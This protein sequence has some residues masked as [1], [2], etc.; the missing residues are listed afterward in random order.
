MPKKFDMRLHRKKFNL[1]PLG[2]T[3]YFLLICAMGMF[4][5]LIWNSFLLKNR[6]MEQ[7]RVRSNIKLEEKYFL[8]D[9][10]SRSKS[11]NYYKNKMKGRDIFQSVK[12]EPRKHREKKKKNRADNSQAEFKRQFRLVGVVLDSNPKAIIVN[13]KTKETLFFLKGEKV[14]IAELIEIFE[15]RIILLLNGKEMEMVL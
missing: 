3:N 11:F 1:T 5:L 7:K 6:P 9:F 2:V 10:L 14:G 15:G 13:S 4:I 12:K 8:D